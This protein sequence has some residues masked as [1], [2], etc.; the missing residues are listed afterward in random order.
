MKKITL[1]FLFALLL[2]KDGQ[3]Q[4]TVIDMTTDTVSLFNHSEKLTKSA[5]LAMLSSAIIPGTGQQYLNRNRSALIYIGVDLLSLFGAV[6]LERYSRQLERDAHGFAAL[7]AQVDCSSK[8]ERFWNA[9]G[10][11]KSL[12]DYHDNLDLNREQDQRYKDASYYWYW[13]SD[14]NQERY[15]EFRDRSRKLHIVG[16][17]CIGAMIVNRIVSVVDIKAATKY[18][19]RDAISLHPT[20]SPDLTSAGVTLQAKF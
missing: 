17:I 1:F 12:N 15:N 16:S 11:S 19:S 7:H 2:S 8:D 14:D 9:V 10:S 3:S 6:F 13:N 5:N 20:F 4:V 18:K